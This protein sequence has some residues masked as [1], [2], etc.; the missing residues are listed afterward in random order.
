MYL[1]IIKNIFNAHP[2]Q[3]MFD[4]SSID[5]TTSNVILKL[6]ANHEFSNGA[7]AGGTLGCIVECVAR[8]VGQNSIGNCFVSRRK[9]R[10]SDFFPAKR[11]GGRSEEISTHSIQRWKRGELAGQKHSVPLF[12][13]T[14]NHRQRQVFFRSIAFY[15]SR[16]NMDYD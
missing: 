11:F 15:E 8:M 2:L 3:T 14:G 16:C 6:N 7:A 10:R 4:V 12:T 5:Y 9:L 1:E 13:K